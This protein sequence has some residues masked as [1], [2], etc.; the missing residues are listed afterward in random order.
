MV[1]GQS[2]DRSIVMAIGIIKFSLF[3][4]VKH[5]LC[6]SVE[7]A[8][9]YKPY[10][11]PEGDPTIESAFVEQDYPAISLRS[12]SI[13]VQV[14]TAALSL[15]RS[16]QAVPTRTPI[17]QYIE[18]P[19]WERPTAYIVPMT[20]IPYSVAP[21]EYPV[22]QSPS[23]TSLARGCNIFYEVRWSTCPPCLAHRNSMST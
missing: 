22:I 10:Y 19:T 4:I 17:D 9:I 11:M 2:L 5:L 3:I 8:M 16:T 15:P 23:C 7:G 20:T 1:R 18:D 14:G 13:T 6:P 21:T 12:P